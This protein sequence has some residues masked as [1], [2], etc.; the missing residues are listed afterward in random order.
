MTLEKY[1]FVPGDVI[2]G[3]VNLNLKKPT[4]ARKMEVKFLGQRKEKCRNSQGKTSYKTTNVFDFS[5]P[6]GPEKDYQKESFNFEIK[7]PSDVIQ[8]CRAPSTPELD[9]A[10][11]K[12]V[13]VGSAL[14]G[15]RYYPVEWMV[16]AQLDVPM[17]LDV[18]KTQKI[19]LS[20]S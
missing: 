13:A 8:Q 7:I 17:K 1:N 2:K 9:G 11:G 18:K 4:K 20:E 19:M 12:V 6:L 10:L 15:N 14:S 5:M 16:H 3:T